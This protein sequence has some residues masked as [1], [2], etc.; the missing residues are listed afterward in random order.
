MT[1]KHFRA[2]A[3]VIRK[4]HTAEITGNGY[5]LAEAMADILQNYNPLFDYNR[6]IEACNIKHCEADECKNIAEQK[7]KNVWYC[8]GHYTQICAIDGI[9]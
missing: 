2:I 4:Y 7:L 8:D 1:K 6:F 5:N 3:E 9:E